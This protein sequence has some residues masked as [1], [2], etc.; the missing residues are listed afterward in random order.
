MKRETLAEAATWLAFGSAAAIV[1][2]I[3]ASQILLGAA[4]V[5]LLVS[6]EPMRLPRIKL[7]LAIF[8]AGTIVAWLASGDLK[9]GLPQIRKLIV[10]FELLVVYS[11]IRA[12]PL[13]KKLML[14]WAALATF[15]GCWG[16]VQFDKRVQ[17]AH[18][19]G[20]DFYTYYVSARIKGFTSHWNTF[21]AEEMFALLMLAAFLFF[22]PKSRR[23]WLWMVSAAVLSISVVL[24]ETRGV[25][26]ALTA[27]M[28]YLIWRWRPWLV[29][30]IPLL[31]GVLFI[32]SPAAIRQRMT[33]IT[34]AKD[35]DSNEF[36][37]VV[38]RTGLRMIEAHPLLGLGPEEQHV[39]FDQYMPADI[40]KKPIGFYGHLHNLYIEYAAERGIP[41]LLVFLWMIAWILL[42]FSRGLRALPPG[43]SDRRF[44]LEGAIAV[45]IGALVEGFFEVNLGDSEPLTMFLVAVACGYLALNLPKDETAPPSAPPGVETL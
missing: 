8:I 29:L 35:V 23:Q 45:V 25:W 20:L 2:S 12:I 27:A 36:R 15:T 40:H 16:F 30:A 31:A 13:V 44:I 22:A 26:I 10:F 14:T 42:D 7:P 4:F 1:L 17:E 43:P 21:S 28:I 9:T 39:H 3:A 32:A 5:A 24:I 41:V 38:W 19:Q 33:S 6:G 34:Q 18:R 11:C 37:L